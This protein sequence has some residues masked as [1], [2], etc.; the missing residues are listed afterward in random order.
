MADEIKTPKENV[1]METKGNI[2][3]ITIDKSKD[4]G[5]SQSG[6]SNLVAST[7]RFMDLGENLFMMLNLV[8]KK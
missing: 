3:T 5:P 2:L 7:G 8:R 6:K 1:K 4:F